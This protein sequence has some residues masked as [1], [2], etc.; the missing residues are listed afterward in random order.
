MLTLY[1]CPD[2]RFMLD[3]GIKIQINLINTIENKITSIKE[4][5]FK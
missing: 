2:I 3:Y 1:Y 5:R 4:D